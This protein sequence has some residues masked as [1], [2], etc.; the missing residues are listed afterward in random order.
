ME[1]VIYHKATCSTCRR[2]L[3]LLRELGVKVIARDMGREPLRGEE[4]DALIG[5]RELRPF[6]NPRNEL[7]RER[8]LKE[9]LPP[10]AEALALLAANPN[11][12]R[13]PLLVAGEQI[14]FG[15]D[16]AAYRRLAGRD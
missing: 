4:L 9:A 11:L 6:F 5:A 12:L 3:Q 8:R 7:Y 2:A 15:L 16:E 1:P 13:R 14:I 10:R